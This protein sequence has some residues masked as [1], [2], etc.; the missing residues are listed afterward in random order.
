MANGNNSKF[1]M[2]IVGGL[3]IA[4]VGMIGLV[5]A[6]TTSDIDR[7]ARDIK[8]MQ[9]QTVSNDKATLKAITEL[10]ERIKH[11][12]GDL[13]EIKDEQKAIRAKLEQ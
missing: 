11:M 8:I 2:W 1:W 6:T 10:T 12:Q 3:V 5:W 7:N 13:T 9:T 4:L